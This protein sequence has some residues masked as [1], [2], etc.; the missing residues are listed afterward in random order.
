LKK[1]EIEALKP[2][3]FKRKSAK[4]EAEKLWKEITK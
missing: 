3:S 4:V 2:K 1:S